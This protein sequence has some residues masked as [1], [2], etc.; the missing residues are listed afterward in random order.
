MITKL[1]TIKMLKLTPLQR[2]DKGLPESLDDVAKAV[3]KHIV[4]IR[5]WKKEFVDNPFADVIAKTT[6]TKAVRPSKNY[7]SK[8]TLQGRSEE[9]DAALFRAVAA[10][11]T[12]AIKLYKQLVGDLIEKKEVTFGLSAD[13]ITRR[14]LEAERRSR[15]FRDGS[16]YRVEDL[17]EGLSVLPKEI[18]ED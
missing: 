1:E 15:D 8:K 9:V 16:G 14:N 13:E 5:K 3:G 12:E 6:P 2:R 4:T 18:C 10:G 7:D 11:K 17:S